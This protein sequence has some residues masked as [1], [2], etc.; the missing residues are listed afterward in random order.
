MGEVKTQFGHE[1]RFTFLR[2]EKVAIRTW[3]DRVERWEHFDIFFCEGC[4]EYQRVK[5]LETAPGID[6]FME[7]ETWRKV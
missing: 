5:V 3:G 2:Q 1:H 7:R 6:S 4:L